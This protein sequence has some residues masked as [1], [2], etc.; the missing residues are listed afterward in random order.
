[1]LRVLYLLFRYVIHNRKSYF[2]FNL[3]M[4]SSSYVCNNR[5]KKLVMKSCSNAAINLSLVKVTKTKKKA[6]FD[7][8]IRERNVAHLPR[9]SFSP[10]SQ[11]LNV[12]KNPL[13]FH[14][15][16]EAY[17]YLIF[18]KGKN[19]GFWLKPLEWINVNHQCENKYF[20]VQLM[21]I[22][23]AIQRSRRHRN[24]TNFHGC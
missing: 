20:L 21:L 9:T 7:I 8:Q 4:Q 17:S 2:F 11:L 12:R 13:I 5:Q 15:N 3:I 23:K 19:N 24:S 16:K 14:R 6:S 10:P 18:S 1:M 22:F